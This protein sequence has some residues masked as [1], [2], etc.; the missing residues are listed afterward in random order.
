M[1][2]VFS[3]SRLG[4]VNVLVVYNSSFIWGNMTVSKQK[5]ITSPS[6]PRDSSNDPGKILVTHTVGLK[7]KMNETWNRTTDCRRKPPSLRIHALYTFLCS[8][9]CW[10]WMSEHHQGSFPQHRV[11]TARNT[12]KPR[13]SSSSGLSWVSQ[14][15]RL[16]HLFFHHPLWTRSQ[17]L[18]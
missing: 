12:L 10:R 2:K 17:L 15:R 4:V 16:F 9:W 5:S 6:M 7:I 1:N 18:N 13:S 11:I 8:H 14:S 3:W